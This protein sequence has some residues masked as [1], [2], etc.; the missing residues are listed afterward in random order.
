[1]FTVLRL[2]ASPLSAA[3]AASWQG[4]LARS[5]RARALA[6]WPL[7][8]AASAGWRLRTSPALARAGHRAPLRGAIIYKQLLLERLEG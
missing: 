3:P 6:L 1:M 7:P 4:R 2:H 8:A 5:P